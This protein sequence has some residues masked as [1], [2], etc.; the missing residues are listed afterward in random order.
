MTESH[1]TR[2]CLEWLNYCKYIGW[3]KSDL[4]ALTDLFWEHEGWKTFRGY[5]GNEWHG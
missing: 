2:L 1:K 3:K 5:R 4:P